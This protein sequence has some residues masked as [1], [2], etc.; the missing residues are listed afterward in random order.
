MRLIRYE[1]DVC[2]TEH[3]G[4]PMIL[5]YSLTGHAAAKQL[6]IC[7]DKCA[8]NALTKFANSIQRPDMGT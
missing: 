8:H 1:C 6:D 4:E 3:K 7:S 5:S 2:H